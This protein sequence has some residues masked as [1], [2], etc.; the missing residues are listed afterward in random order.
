MRAHVSDY[1][2]VVTTSV[3]LVASTLIIVY[4]KVQPPYGGFFLAPAEG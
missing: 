4:E 2:A 3:L 1:R